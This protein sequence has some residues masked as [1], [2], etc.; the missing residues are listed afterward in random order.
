MKVLEKERENY[1]TEAEDVMK[2]CTESM[3]EVSVCLYVCL[4]VYLFVYVFTG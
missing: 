4:F 3:D 1:F 2:Q